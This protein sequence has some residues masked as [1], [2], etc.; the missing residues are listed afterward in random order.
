MQVFHFFKSDFSNETHE[1]WLGKSNFCQKDF[2]GFGV[3]IVKYF[4]ELI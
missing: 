2:D 3:S 4:K 1:I